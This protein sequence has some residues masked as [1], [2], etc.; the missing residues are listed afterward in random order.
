MHTK[1]ESNRHFGVRK[2]TLPVIVASGKSSTNKSM[3]GLNY[4][5]QKKKL[6]HQ[7]VSMNKLTVYFNI[8]P[9]T[10]KLSPSIQMKSCF[11]LIKNKANTSYFN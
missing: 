7:S 4:F 2:V 11:R 9:P 5:I 1:S 6:T 10:N 8:H 3:T